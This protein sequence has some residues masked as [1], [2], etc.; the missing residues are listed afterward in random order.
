MASTFLS[1]HAE[2]LLSTK[3]G[4]GGL[5]VLLPVLCVCLGHVKLLVGQTAHPPP[6][7]PNNY[8][9]PVKQLEFHRTDLEHS[10]TEI[11]TGQQGLA[12]VIQALLVIA[13]LLHKY[14]KENLSKFAAFDH[15][16]LL[17]W[18]Q[19]EGVYLKW[20]GHFWIQSLICADGCLGN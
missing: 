10:S 11:S 3:N 8:T 1:F 18:I 4:R 14:D 20:E 9:Y 15:V 17:S 12:I 5:F 6:F 16:Q 7:Y 2:P 19:R 13:V